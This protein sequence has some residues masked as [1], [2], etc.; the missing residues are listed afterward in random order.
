MPSIPAPILE[1]R[2]LAVR[3]PAR[4]GRITA[5]ADV[6]LTIARG[7]CIGIVGESGAGKS[8]LLLAPFRLAASRAEVAGEA[9]LAGEGLLALDAR[10]LDRLRGAHVGFVFQDP[11]ST[12][13]P[14]RTV[15]AHLVEVL[16]HH[17][18]AHGATARTRAKSLLERVGIDAPERR[19][20]QYP[21]ELSGGQRQRVAIALA[22]AC[23]PGLMIADEPTTA[24]DVTVQAG[25]LAMLGTLKRE[26]QL[27]IALVSHDF[28]VVG[29]LADRLY[30][31]YAGRIVEHG[32]TEALTRSPAHPY[33]AALLACIPR[34]DDPPDAPLEAI[35]GQPPDPRALPTGCAFHPRCP[36]ADAQCR[37]EVPALVPGG[38]RD[39]ACHHPLRP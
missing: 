5:V 19:L 9:L 22:L 8:Q 25:I 26:G 17:G 13:T 21:H 28:G 35:P 3:F 37:T 15:G 6:T 32:P 31:M 30:V 36:R 14:H 16:E 10:A 23:E 38:A 4:E 39:V 27:A 11:L 12:L 1:L 24:L 34:M 7:E 29:C 20:T 2:R 33:T 18:R